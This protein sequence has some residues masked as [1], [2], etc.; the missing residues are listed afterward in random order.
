MGV[1][2]IKE[3]TEF[4]NLLGNMQ[5]IEK[6]NVELEAK[7]EQL[8]K[9]LAAEK[10]DNK[11]LKKYQWIEDADIDYWNITVRDKAVV[12]GLLARGAQ[13]FGDR[14]AKDVTA[15]DKE[16]N[17]YARQHMDYIVTAAVKYVILH[18]DAW[19]RCYAKYIKD[20]NRAKGVED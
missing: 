1:A 4:Q 12:E 20:H 2:A 10:E 8:Q 16:I 13:V 11:H 19:V 6:H 9:A 3:L 7:V 18:E 5:A 14:F 17:R 15:D